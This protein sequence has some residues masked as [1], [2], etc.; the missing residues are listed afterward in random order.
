MKWRQ[1]NF[2]KHTHTHKC[3]YMVQTHTNIYICIYISVFMTSYTRK[4]ESLVKTPVACKL[5]LFCVT[6]RISTEFKP[7]PVLY[8]ILPAL[9][10][11][12]TKEFLSVRFVIC[13]ERHIAAYLRVRIAL[14]ITNKCTNTQIQML[15]NFSN[16]PELI[17][18]AVKTKQKFS[19]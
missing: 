16:F 7:Y 5:S 2:P 13:D 1:K 12:N 19:L 6:C 18:H 10:R 14:Q 4:L 11:D 3:V 17:K 8:D 15:L 9:R